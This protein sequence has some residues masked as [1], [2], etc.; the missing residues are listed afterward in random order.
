MSGKK[1]MASVARLGGLA[2]K[3][4][5][6]PDSPCLCCNRTFPTWLSFIGHLGMRQTARR[7]FNGDVS[8]AARQLCLNALAKEERGK[9]WANGAWA[10]RYR[11]ITPAARIA[12]LQEDLAHARLMAVHGA[13][14]GVKAAARM[15]IQQIETELNAL[16]EN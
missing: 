4:K 10:S 16:Q 5:A 15:A 14:D 9:S 1:N 8:A 6:A 12:R 7:Y 13:T 2:L 3:T 11:P